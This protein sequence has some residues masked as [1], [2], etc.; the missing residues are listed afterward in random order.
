MALAVSFDSGTLIGLGEQPSAD[1]M[2]R[3][4]L[5]LTALYVERPTHTAEEQQQYGELAL[6][7]IDK[8]EAGMRAAV[9]EMLHRHPD[10]PAQVIEH[11]SGAQCLGGRD[12]NG[13][14]H[15]AP[16]Q[17]R[18]GDQPRESN[19]HLVAGQDTSAAASSGAPAIGQPPAPLP[20]LHAGD[21]GER[22]FGDAFFAASPAERRRL[23]APMARR[24]GDDAP[25]APEDGERAFGSVGVAALHGRISEFACELERLIDI[26]RSLC[27]RIMSDP[28]GEPMVVTAKAAGMPIAILQ[29][30]LL[31]VCAAATHSVE[32]VYDLTELYHGLDAR[33]ARDLLVQWRTQAKS[34]DPVPD[35]EA[36]TGDR[37]PGAPRPRRWPPQPGEGQAGEGRV[38]ASLRSRFDA[39]TD[40]VRSQAVNARCDRGNV[41]RRGP[42]SR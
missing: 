30:I 10:A 5:A 9:A 2:A 31:L 19:P 6:R 38:G 34:S 40:R 4:L 16:D 36:D 28:S 27:E 15:S 3:L 33:A 24:Y 42:R 29:R 17:Y 7:L 20:P 13:G 23:L 21:G 18:A 39:L 37:T 26:P 12:T 1:M 41:A 35:T 22:A 11:L 8:V 25:V 14:R 32:R